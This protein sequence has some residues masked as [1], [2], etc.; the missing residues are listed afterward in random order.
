MAVFELRVGGEIY[1][2]W[3]SLRV[4]RGLERATADFALRVSEKWPILGE[5][6]QIMPGSTCE[7]YLDD[8]LVLTGYVD[9]YRPKYSPTSHDI[10]CTGRSRTCDFVDSS[11]TD[12]D[13]Q[14]KGLTPG[15]LARMLA[16]PFD[17]E[18][19]A[20]YEGEPIPDAQQQQ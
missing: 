5:A 15:E 11:I 13:G 10:E 9:A 17:I 20:D 7:I 12:T 3:K 8:E 16:A 6:W 14:F 19:V 1:S 4:T 2:G 18:V